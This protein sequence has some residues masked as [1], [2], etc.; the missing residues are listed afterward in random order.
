MNSLIDPTNVTGSFPV[1]QTADIVYPLAA[2]GAVVAPNNGTYNTANQ[3]VTGMALVAPPLQGKFLLPKAS[4]YTANDPVWTAPAGATVTSGPP[5]A[6]PGANSMAYTLT[7]PDGKDLADPQ[8]KRNVVLLRRLAN[9][10]VGGGAGT[11]NPYVTVDVMDWVPSFD[12]VSRAAGQ[13]TT[14]T[15]RAAKAA[16]NGTEYDPITERFSLGKVQ[17]YAGRSVGNLP[18]AGQFYNTYQFPV[19]MVLPQNPSP[20]ATSIKHSCSAGTTA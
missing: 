1:G 7:M 6:S 14:R 2:S 18:P 8:F 9:P 15:S 5:A 13:M 19:S 12:A 10:Y 17:P 3:C 20:A 11:G 4:E 16:G